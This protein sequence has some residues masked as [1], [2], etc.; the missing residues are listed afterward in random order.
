[1]AEPDG[2]IRARGSANARRELAPLLREY[3]AAVMSVLQQRDIVLMMAAASLRE[4]R[5]PPTAV[6][7]CAFLMPADN[8]TAD[9]GTNEKTNELVGEIVEPKGF[10][11]ARAGILLESE[12]R[13]NR[14]GSDGTRPETRSRAGR[15]CSCR[16]T[17]DPRS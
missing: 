15:P 17:F 4:G 16:G 6:A 9:Y 12:R 5:W 2:L 8:V 3:K 14:H 10:R 13:T 7:V 11:A 1:V